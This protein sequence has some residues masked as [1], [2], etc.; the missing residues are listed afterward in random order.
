MFQRSMINSK[1]LFKP[2]L[3]LLFMRVP[4]FGETNPMEVS[5]IFGLLDVLSIRCAVL[6]LLLMARTST[7]FT[8]MFKEA[9]LSQYLLYI[10]DNCKSW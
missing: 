10:R 7:N 2:K 6:N 5:P 3:E 8:K 9:L 4:R 1:D